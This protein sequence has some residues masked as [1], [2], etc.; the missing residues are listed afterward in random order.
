MTFLFGD[1]DDDFI[2]GV[3]DDGL[4]DAIEKFLADFL[5]GD[6]LGDVKDNDFGDNVE[7]IEELLVGFLYGDR[8]GDLTL[9]GDVILGIIDRRKMMRQ[10][11]SYYLL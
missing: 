3:A 2:I 7:G 10:M 8:T 5:Y 9:P 6:G 11:S 4:G 1:G